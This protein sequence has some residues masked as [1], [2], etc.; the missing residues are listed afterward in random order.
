MI[1]VLTVIGARP[2]FI[3][4]A[5]ISR[6]IREHYS[7]KIREVIVH[8]GQH[9]D[10]EM[11]QV[12]FEQLGIPREDYNLQVGSG[13]HGVQ[14]ARMIT[15]LEEI[16][17]KERP[18]LVILYGDTNS[19]LAGAVAASKLCIPIV[20]IEAGMRSFTKQVPEE[21][22][23]IMCDHVST[24]LF[25]PTW[26]GVNNL[27]KEG[28]PKDN[29]GPYTVD[30]PKVF[31]CGDIMYDNSLH[32]REVAIR[33]SKILE[34]S[35]VTSGRFSLVTVHRQNNTDDAHRLHAIFEAL[36]ELADS[37]K[38]TFVVPLHPRTR[39]ILSQ[40]GNAFNHPGV[41]IIAPVSYL[42]M[43]MLESA[44]EMVITDS[45]GVQKEAYYFNKPCIILQ[46][47]TPW[48]ELVDSGCALLAD[49]DK[50]KIVAAFDHFRKQSGKLKFDPVFGDGRAAEFTVSEIIRCFT[51]K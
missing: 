42:D 43:I 29:L 10:H 26:T 2:Q 45:G 40:N 36:S 38:T 27:Y 7:E 8:T 11:S 18:H 48:V 51:Y 37:R 15:G 3:K 17:V 12:F 19:T 6:A 4:A 5:A 47:E 33:D 44:A 28:F 46:S 34:Q 30:N 1:H 31:H 39:K 25:T 50:N 20:H 9:Y 14:T 41:E 23:R 32:F 24:L 21:I 22:N 13:A 49:A 16:L 35:G